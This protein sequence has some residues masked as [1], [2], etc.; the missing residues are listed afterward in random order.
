MLVKHPLNSTTDNITAA[1]A[2]A[3]GVIACM[4]G[5]GQADYDD[6][7]VMREKAVYKRVRARLDEWSPVDATTGLKHMKNAPSLT[8]ISPPPPVSVP[9][10]ITLRLTIDDQITNVRAELTRKQKASNAVKGSKEAMVDH[11]EC[12]KLRKELARLHK[13]K[14]SGSGPYA[15]VFVPLSRVGN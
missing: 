13:L 1:T 3:S 10:P 9:E 7:A 6:D 2:I 14:D 15:D 11:N 4:L 12:E 8:L 5:A